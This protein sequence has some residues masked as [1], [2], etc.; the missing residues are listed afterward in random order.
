MGADNIKTH[1]C[2]LVRGKMQQVA[3]GFL[4]YVPRVGENIS[5]IARNE[6]THLWDLVYR[7]RVEKVSYELFGNLMP[8]SKSWVNDTQGGG[9]QVVLEVTPIDDIAREYCEV[10]AE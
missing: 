7:F 9:C 3:L 4:P 2:C 6:E 5:L 8:A 10:A 1:F